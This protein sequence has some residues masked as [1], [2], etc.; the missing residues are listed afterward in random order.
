MR[1]EDYAMAKFGIPMDNKYEQT[2]ISIGRQRGFTETDV[3]ELRE[4]L[5][6]YWISN[7]TD[8]QITNTQYIWFSLINYN[9]N[10]RFTKAL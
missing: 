1:N 4:I 10:V 5:L 8:I 9:I 6:K 7:S 3:E 2:L